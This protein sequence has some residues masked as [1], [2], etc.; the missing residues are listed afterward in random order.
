MSTANQTSTDY[1]AALESLGYIIRRNE[2]TREIETNGETYNE[3]TEARIRAEMWDRGFKN[4]QLVSDIVKV[5]AEDNSY[6]PIREQLEK[7]EPW[8]GTPRIAALSTYLKPENPALAAVL[9]RKWWIAAVSKIYQETQNMILV[10]QGEQGTG[11]SCFAKW[12]AS[13][14]PARYFTADKLDPR[15]KDDQLKATRTAIWEIGELETTTTRADMGDLKRFVTQDAF[16]IRRPYDKC[17]ARIPVTASFIGTVN[18]TGGFLVDP[19]GNRRFLMIKSEGID[20]SYRDAFNIGDL[21]AEAYAAFKAGEDFTLT[22]E[23]A[24]ANEQEQDAAEI[25]D[26]VAEAIKDLF[27]IDPT[28]KDWATPCSKVRETLSLKST[29]TASELTSRKL[30]AAAAALGL[31]VKT[32]R[33]KNKVCKCYLGIR[34][35]EPDYPIDRYDN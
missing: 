10:I 14:F 27:D 1:R 21:W 22:A 25:V 20:F 15:D 34:S 4:R 33:A 35:S 9:L 28:R 5:E 3:F 17:D 29:L 30:G 24:A 7:L 16:T 26:L 18:P 23:E 12:I 32:V 6:H 13:L 8:D 19:S 11:K 31:E 2:M